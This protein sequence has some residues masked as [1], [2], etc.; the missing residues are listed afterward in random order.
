VTIAQKGLLLEVY[1]NND[2]IYLVFKR[3]F[4]NLYAT[5]ELDAVL[6]LSNTLQ[7]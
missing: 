1:S 2:S 3:I 6:V 5:V 7:Y 4:S